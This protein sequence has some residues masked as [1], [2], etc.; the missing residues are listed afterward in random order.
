MKK[1]FFT[2]LVSVALIHC[3]YSQTNSQQLATIDKTTA[4]IKNNLK[5]YQKIEK[6]N[7]SISSK[8]VYKDDN[9]VRLMTVSYKEIDVNKTVEWYFSNGEIIHTQQTWTS[10]LF[11]TMDSNEKCYFDKGHLIA[12]TRNNIPADP[13]SQEFK[14]LEI[15]W[16]K[17]VE[18][19]KKW[20]QK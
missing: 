11:K 12:W 4:E 10:S 3:I 20:A 19:I 7:D 17:T 14:D 1:Y 9:E 8:Y 16:A 15:S 6:V 18:E 5:N 13:N 2:V